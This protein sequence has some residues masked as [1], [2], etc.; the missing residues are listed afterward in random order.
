MHDK[1]RGSHKALNPFGR[2]ARLSRK[3]DSIEDRL[4][5]TE[6]TIDW[7]LDY[8]SKGSYR[9][10]LKI[11]IKTMRL[12]RETLNKTKEYIRNT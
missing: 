4:V 11:A 2:K 10:A 9:D 5:C 7:I 3:I 6:K 8:N 12:A 1:W